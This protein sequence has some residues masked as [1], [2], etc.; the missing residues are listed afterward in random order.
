MMRGAIDFI[1]SDR[2]LRSKLPKWMQG[3]SSCFLLGIQ[4]LH[5]TDGNWT[6][7]GISQSGVNEVEN[8]CVDFELPFSEL[9][10]P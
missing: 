5:D 3:L 8:I 7:T 10:F 2:K 1:I 9:I 6:D 4:R